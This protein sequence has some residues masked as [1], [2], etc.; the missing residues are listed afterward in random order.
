MYRF[1]IGLCAPIVRGWGRLEV[2]GIECLPT[3]GPTLLVPNHDSYWDP[4]TFGV[5]ALRHR[6]MRA[7]TKDSLWRVPVLG[8]M[9]DGMGQIPIIRGGGDAA[10]MSRAEE[11]LRNGA[12]IAVFPEGTRSKGNELQPRGGIARLARAVPEAT[13]VCGAVTGTVDIVKVPRR[14]RLKVVF[15]R[16]P[17]P[18]PLP[19]ETD[20]EFAG[21]LL[22]ATRQLAPVVAAGR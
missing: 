17:D 7:L 5:A 11:A 4:P 15:F 19:G 6:H 9:L 1:A 8:L 22:S 3:S 21:R 10:A 20:R 18:A 16:P 12:C 2:E 13:I 14:P